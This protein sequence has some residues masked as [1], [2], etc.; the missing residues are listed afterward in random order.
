MRYE[1]DAIRLGFSGLLRV[2]GLEFDQHYLRTL[3]PRNPSVGY[4]DAPETL[5]SLRATLGSNTEVYSQLFFPKSVENTPTHRFEEHVNVKYGLSLGSYADL[6]SWS[7]TEFDAFWSEVWDQ[8]DVVGHKGNH[9][10]DKSALPPD[11]PPWFS[12]ARLNWAENMLRCRSSEKTALIEASTFL[13]CE[14][15]AFAKVDMHS[16]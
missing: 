7:T 4:M 12:E 1:F 8:T 14:S 5:P 16:V 3:F 2:S 11:N 15:P 10:V 6:H 9:V 13:P